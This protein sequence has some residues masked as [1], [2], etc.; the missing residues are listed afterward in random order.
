MYYVF[1]YCEFTLLIPI[2]DKLARSKYKWLGFVISPL[3]I[4]TMRLIPLMTGYEVNWY[5]GPI[6]RVSCLGWFTYYYLG[7][8]LGNGLLKIK[9]PTSRIFIMWVGAL[10][11]QI[12]EGL[13]YFSMG[14]QNCGTQLKLS[15]V[16]T[17]VLFVL[18]GY[19]YIYLDAESVPAPKILHVL[20]DYSF[21]IFFLHLAVMSALD[22]LPHY[23]KIIIFPLDAVIVI[24]VSL[25]FV[26]IGKRI[27]GR[28]ANYLAL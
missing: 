1:V 8:M 19:I 17:G 15:A 27:L 23:S 22:H 2:I 28:Y 12:A 9:L 13:W 16:L 3:E 25:L 11:L 4:I 26:V 7:Y 21:G 5:V 6:M 18:L 20:G 14:E 24:S 10:G